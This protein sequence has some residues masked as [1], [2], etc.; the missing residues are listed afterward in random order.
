MDVCNHSHGCNGT[1]FS[2][3]SFKRFVRVP[4][5]SSLHVCRHHHVVCYFWQ[6]GQPPATF[7]GIDSR[8]TVAPPRYGQ[9]ATCMWSMLW[10]TR[11]HCAQRSPPSIARRPLRLYRS[12][13]E[14]RDDDLSLITVDRHGRTNDPNSIIRSVHGCASLSRVWCFKSQ[15]HCATCRLH[16]KKTRI[17]DRRNRQESPCKPLIA[18]PR[19]MCYNIEM[20]PQ[21]ISASQT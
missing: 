10:T 11:L 18:P 21:R 12:V 19:Y 15:C 4:S 7:A 1:G 16:A 6:A 14:Y 20:P 9:R 2:T 17:K 8:P 5:V 3:D 13:L